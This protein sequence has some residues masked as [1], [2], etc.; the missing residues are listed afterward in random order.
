MGLEAQV[1]YKRGNY[2]RLVTLALLCALSMTA[3]ESAS[4]DG[5]SNVGFQIGR[6]DNLYAGFT[7]D[8]AEHY[9]RPILIMKKAEIS[10]RIEEY[11]MYTN[12][13]VNIRKNTG[14]DTEIIKTLDPNTLV[15]VTDV[16]GEWSRISMK[17]EICGYIKS[18][19]LSKYE[20]PICGLN[21]WGIDLAEDEVQLLAQIV[22][23]EAGIDSMEGKEAVIESIFNRMVF[24][25][26][27]QGDLY[28][29]LSRQGQYA[30]WISRNN[31]N[32]GEEEYLAIERV[33]KGATYILDYNYVYFS[34]QKSNGH[35]FIKIGKHWFGRE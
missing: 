15:E 30:T 32:P 22:Y 12:C 28:S 5:I 20:T 11:P 3:G 18:E 23:L 16:K 9:K 2:L 34:L 17:D 1:P 25:D 31:A 29:V 4:K 24:S 27:Y 26:S 8:I 35:D 33:L 19:F 7:R 13:Y 10:K 21:R 6:Y 14:T